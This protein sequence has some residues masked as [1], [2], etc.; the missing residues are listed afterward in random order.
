MGMHFLIH[1][2][3]LVEMM[4]TN[5]TPRT[6]EGYEQIIGRI[7]PKLGNI[8]LVQLKPD[9][10]QRYYADCL[11]NGC[12]VRPGGLSPQTVR[13]HHTMLHLALKTDMEWGL[14]SRNPCD[15]VHPPHASASEI[16]IIS[17]NETHTFLDAA[18]N[19]G[20]CALYYTILFTG[21]RRSE[22]LALR[23]CDIDLLLCT[24]SVSRS[25]HRL[26]TGEYIFRQPK[27]TKGRRTI[28]L[29]PSIVKV[30]KDYRES[31]NTERLML[32]SSLKE[33][34]LVFS[35]YDG[36]PIRPDTIT[37]AWSDLAKRCG[38]A[39]HRL[40]D[41]RHSHAS[42]MLK[43][44]IHPRI[45]QERLGHSTIAVTPD[46]YSHVS[47]GL[48]EAAATRFDDALRVRHNEDIVEKPFANR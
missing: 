42:L 27:S 23:W 34:D 28:A 8:P 46:T 9:A 13:H 43:Q 7:I 14:I 20:Y 2:T 31:T 3:I 32:G 16:N 44:G 15:A 21:M 1:S 12:L 36:S 6:I 24:I 41:A 38:I 30:L 26:H 25:I 18:R 11:S 17:E 22:V 39:T 37:R 35:K 40:R 19:T 33:T 47:P 29:T 4:S 5:H 48:Q 45:V 10:L